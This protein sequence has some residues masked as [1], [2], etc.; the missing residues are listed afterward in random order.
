MSDHPYEDLKKGPMSQDELAAQEAQLRAEL[1]EEVHGGEAPPLPI[2]T[3]T[4]IHARA[5]LNHRIT[6]INEN[7]ELKR[8]TALGGILRTGLA[9]SE[10]ARAEIHKLLIARGK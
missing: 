3:K 7:P 10:K 4:L 2:S 8:E 5:A 6:G 9:E 1:E